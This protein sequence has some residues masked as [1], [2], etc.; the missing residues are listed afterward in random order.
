MFA[1]LFEICG[2]AEAGCIHY[3]PALAPRRAWYVSAILVISPI[4]QFAMHVFH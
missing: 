3:C 2:P 1:D 4:I